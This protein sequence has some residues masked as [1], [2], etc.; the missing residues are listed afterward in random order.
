MYS[1]STVNIPNL[2]TCIPSSTYRVASLSLFSFYNVPLVPDVALP[3][4]LERTVLSIDF[5]FII[6]HSPNT[7]V[8]VNRN[9]YLA[10]GHNRN[11]DDYWRILKPFLSPLDEANKVGKVV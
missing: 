9:K 10:L 3:I 6:R 2:P 7:S 4:V 1:L 11:R 8:M 5:L